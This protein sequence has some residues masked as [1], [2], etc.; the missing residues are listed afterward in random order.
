[1]TIEELAFRRARN[2][3]AFSAYRRRQSR[4]REFEYQQKMA[5]VGRVK[6]RHV[7]RTPDDYRTAYSM[8]ELGASLRTIADHF[9]V[10]KSR[11]AQIAAKGE[12]LTFG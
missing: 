11:A 12:R 8:R 6:Q 9:A 1:M 10:S 2:A 7:R 3:T 5:D 4:L